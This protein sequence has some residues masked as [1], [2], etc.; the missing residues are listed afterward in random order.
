[1]QM[2]PGFPSDFTAAPSM[3]GYLFQVRY[4]LALLL[5]AENPE[6]IISIEKFDDI[7]FEEGGEPKEL[8]QTKHRTTRTGSLSDSS[9]DLWKTLKIWAIAAR[10]G[11]IDVS[12]AI[13]SLV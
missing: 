5:R 13:L 4:A 8:L 11:K 3:L 9:A 10:E 12:A 2:L 6:S 7:A 1:M